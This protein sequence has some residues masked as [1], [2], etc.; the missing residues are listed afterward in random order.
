[1]KSSTLAG[2][3][4]E[5]EAEEEVEEE[6]EEEEGRGAEEVEEDGG[7]CEAVDGRERGR[8]AGS[9]DSSADALVAAA[10]RSIQLS[11]LSSSTPHL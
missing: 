8:A 4:D 10:M 6:E 3:E 9:M 2:V 11:F 7:G 1:M 5:E